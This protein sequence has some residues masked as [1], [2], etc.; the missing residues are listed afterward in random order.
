MQLPKDS[1]APG[2]RVRYGRYT[3]RRLRRRGHDALAD[4]LSA[5]TSALKAA[6]RAREDAEES[7]EDARADRDAAD[8][9]LDL[10]AQE[11][12]NTLAGRSLDAAKTSPYTE[13]FPEGIGHYTAA[14]LDAQ[15]A[16][17]K[18]LRARAEAHLAKDDAVRKALLTGIDKGLDAW[19]AGRSAVDDALNDVAQA[20]VALAKATD[21]WT[22]QVEKTYGALV[23]SVGR[24]RAEAYFRRARSA[25][26][27]DAPPT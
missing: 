3:I 1:A 23:Q 15:E 24:T 8:E 7:A 18:Q 21:A 22:R 26:K 25:A 2:V 19:R 5:V 9:S 6:A 4:D 16:R 13:L 20:E 27:P 17:Y 14:A 11:A 10:V 12:R